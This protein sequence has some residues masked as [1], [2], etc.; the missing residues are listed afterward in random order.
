MNADTDDELDVVTAI[1]PEMFDGLTDEE[2]IDD[3]HLYG[4][5]TVRS[6]CRRKMI[7]KVRRIWNVLATFVSRSAKLAIHLQ[8]PRLSINVDAFYVCKMK[9]WEIVHRL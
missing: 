2:D 4:D 9:I 6:K 8:R 1:P 7:L 3:E 5:D